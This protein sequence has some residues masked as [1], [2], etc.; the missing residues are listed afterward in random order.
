MPVLCVTCDDYDS[1]VCC[2]IMT[3]LCNAGGSRKLELP[4]LLIPVCVCQCL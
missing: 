4:L 1:V 2:M 3:V